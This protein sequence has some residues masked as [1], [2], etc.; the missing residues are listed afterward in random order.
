MEGAGKKGI[1]AQR[2]NDE[3]RNVKDIN[4]TWKIFPV[5]TSSSRTSYKRFAVSVPLHPSTVR[6]SFA[7][8]GQV[9]L[10]GNHTELQELFMF[11]YR[12]PLP[13]SLRSI[14]KMRHQAPRIPCQTWRTLGCPFRDTGNVSLRSSSVNDRSHSL[15][16]SARFFIQVFQ[17][18]LAWSTE[19]RLTTGWSCGRGKQR[20]TQL[21]ILG[22]SKGRYAIS[23]TTST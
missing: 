19:G 8:L 13:A 3:P 5:H 7:E 18:K 1:G 9:K 15:R 2:Y 16:Q 14:C 21:R 10:R 11:L 12:S 17:K 22:G 20:G 23:I 6:D 4:S